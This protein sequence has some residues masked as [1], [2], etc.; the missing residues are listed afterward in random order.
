MKVYMAL[1]AYT[2]TTRVETTMAICE[3]I[4]IMNKM[5][6]DAH[7][8]VNAGDSILPRCRNMFLRDFYNRSEFTHF[9][10]LDH[11]ITWERG[12]MV[13]LLQSPVDFV[14][15]VYPKRKD[16]IE[17]PVRWIEGQPI[18]M[19]NGL[20]EVDGVPT[21]FMRLTRRCVAAMMDKYWA[22]AYEEEGL[23]PPLAINLC[24]FALS[25]GKYIGEDYVLCRRWRD[26]GGRIYIDPAIKF[27]HIG[28]KRF[29]GALLDHL[30]ERQS[31]A[32]NVVAMTGDTGP[33]PVPKVR[34]KA[35]SS[36]VA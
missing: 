13:R 26:M 5:G 34:V 17:Y 8:M 14:A 22:L 33:A 25:G 7:L 24:E 32:N 10:F 23:D 3:E 31:K 21:G 6:I 15:G 11:D 1:P 20:I 18:Q 12:A 2:G 28:F 19:E 35:T 4:Q 30:N 36:E 27:N 9:F 16:P 29:E